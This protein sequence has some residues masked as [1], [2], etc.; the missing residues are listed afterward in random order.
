MKSTSRLE[1][2]TDVQKMRETLNLQRD[3]TIHQL[4][5]E[6]MELQKNEFQRTD[7]LDVLRLKIDEVKINI[8]ET[9]L[10]KSKIQQENEGV[11]KDQASKLVD[12]K[13][14]LDKYQ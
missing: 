2:S 10:V 3:Q 1:A 4:E 5:N 7:T 14:T 9:Q 13:F 8:Q 11:L 6:I 12:L